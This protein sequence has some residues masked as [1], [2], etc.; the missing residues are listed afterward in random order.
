MAHNKKATCWFLMLELYTSM[1]ALS[2]PCS[3]L[4]RWQLILCFSNKTFL[5][6]SGNSQQLDQQG[7]NGPFILKWCRMS[8]LWTPEIS[9]SFYPSFS[10]SLRIPSLLILYSNLLFFYVVW[11][12]LV[13]CAPIRAE[14]T[15][16]NHLF[17]SRKRRIIQLGPLWVT[18]G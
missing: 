14:W 18:Q 11:L 17:L 16:I 1:T 15:I 12:G 8:I 5:K 6:T 9:H 4:S 13:F 7:T 2:L 10:V 3:M